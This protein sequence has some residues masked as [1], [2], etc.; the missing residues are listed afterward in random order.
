MKTQKQE[1][2]DWWNGLGKTNRDELSLEYFGLLSYY[3]LDSEIEQIWMKEFPHEK[4]YT[5][6]ELLNLCENAYDSGRYSIINKD[7]DETF[8]K[9]VTENL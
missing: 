2:I 3:T 1:A 9:W 8:D 4:T 7:I 5:K 6:E